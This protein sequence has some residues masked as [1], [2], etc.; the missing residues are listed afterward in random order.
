MVVVAYKNNNNNSGNNSVIDQE[1]CKSRKRKRRHRRAN[2]KRELEQQ[3]EVNI[4]KSNVS[5]NIGIENITGPLHS[6]ISTTNINMKESSQQQEYYSSD[7]IEIESSPASSSKIAKR[8]KTPDN[9]QQ[10][11]G[12]GGGITTI[13]ANVI[14]EKEIA[15]INYNE[16]T[17]PQNLKK[18][19]LPSTVHAIFFI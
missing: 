10:L 15:I 9:S 17:I 7:D 16:D 2:K 13:T 4:N 3:P 6:D 12:V 5:K 11:K 8:Q 1:T 18:H 14:E 19:V